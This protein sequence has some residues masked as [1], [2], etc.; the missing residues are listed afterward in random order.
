MNVVKVLTRKIII[1][2]A[3]F[4]KTNGHTNIDK[5]KVT[6]LILLKRVYHFKIRAKLPYK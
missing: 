4:I 1:I 2:K 6:V 5:F 3:K